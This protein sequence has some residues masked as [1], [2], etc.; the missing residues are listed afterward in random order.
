MSKPNYAYKQ[1][2]AKILRTS[3]QS[4]FLACNAVLLATILVT[5]RNN[6]RDNKKIHPTLI[7]LLIAWFPLIVRGIF[8]V[9]QSADWGL[10][11][12]NRMHPLLDSH[13]SFTKALVHS[14]ELPEHRIYDSIHCSWICS[15][16]DDR[17]DRVCFFLDFHHDHASDIC[18]FYSRCLVLNLSYFTSK[19]DPPRMS[20]EEFNAWTQSSSNPK[21]DSELRQ[22]RNSQNSDV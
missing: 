22:L 3:G 19:N 4:I 8:G 16:C 21:T 18:L 11:Y 5:I 10:S 2:I 1:N 14:R 17:M 7:L 13:G 6:R 12:Y 20:K 9:L 15:W